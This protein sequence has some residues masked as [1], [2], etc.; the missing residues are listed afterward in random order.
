MFNLNVFGVIF[1]KTTMIDMSNAQ[2]ESQ[3]PKRNDEAPAPKASNVANDQN[4][5]V[6]NKNDKV[7]IMRNVLFLVKLFDG[8]KK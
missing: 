8:Q 7:M 2:N 3:N 5:N 4:Q 1:H 6:E